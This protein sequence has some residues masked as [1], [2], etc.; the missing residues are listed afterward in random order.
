M[1]DPFCGLLIEKLPNL[2]RY[3]LSLCRSGDQ[4]DDLV[5]STVERA[6]RARDGFDPD[7]RIEAWL[8]RILRNAWIDILRK[9]KVRGPEVAIDNAPEFAD[10]SGHRGDARLMVANVLDAVARLPDAQREV[11]LLVSV[12]GLSYAE[13][14]DILEIPKGTVMS[15][16]CRARSTLAD[17]MDMSAE[18]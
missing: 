15:R 2:R 10:E 7:S 18:L 14:A 5:Q 17:K 3:A 12:E 11:V 9:N 1:T 8:F 4:A 6:L 16:L 13:A